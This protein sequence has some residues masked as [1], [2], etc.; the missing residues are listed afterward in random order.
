M[1]GE[2]KLEEE[3]QCHIRGLVLKFEIISDAGLM[4]HSVKKSLI[5]F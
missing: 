1:P 5:R 3:C 4:F 2:R